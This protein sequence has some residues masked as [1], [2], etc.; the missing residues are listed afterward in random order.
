MA[1][2][3]SIFDNRLSESDTAKLVTWTGL[4]FTTADSGDPVQWVDCADRCVQV[5][6]TFGVGGSLTIEGSNNGVDFLALSD[7][8]GNPLT[9]TSSRIEQVLELPRYVRPRVTAG[10]ATTNLDVLLCMRRVTRS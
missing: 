4:K 3:A 7:P 9:F 8:Q 10:D 2:I 1:V 6:G 5:L